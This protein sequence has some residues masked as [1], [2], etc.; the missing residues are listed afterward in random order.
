MLLPVSPANY[1]SCQQLRHSE[2]YHQASSCSTKLIHCFTHR[3]CS[4]LQLSDHT[5]RTLQHVSL[6]RTHGM[7]CTATAQSGLSD[8]K[9]DF[10]NIAHM[11]MN[12][13]AACM[14]QLGYRIECLGCYCAGLPIHLGC[15]VHRYRNLSVLFVDFCMRSSDA[16]SLLLVHMQTSVP[17]RGNTRTTPEQFT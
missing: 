3:C 9:S 8:L 7:Q 1:P 10:M 13:E 14:H 15:P 5:V 4:H 17:I 16:V 12:N 6:T 2:L 11:H